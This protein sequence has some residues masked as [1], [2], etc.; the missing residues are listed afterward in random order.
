VIFV[1][2]DCGYRDLELLVFD[3]QLLHEA[4]RDVAGDFVGQDHER[5]VAGVAALPDDDVVGVGER[6]SEVAPAPGLEQDAVDLHGEDDPRAPVPDDG[7]Q[8][9]VEVAEALLGSHG[10]DAV[11]PGGELRIPG[12]HEC[13]SVPRPDVGVAPSPEGLGRLHAHQG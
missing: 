4:L 3:L 1:S 12:R 11:A 2:Q 8:P 7:L 9:G 6:E 13:G 10:D 5:P